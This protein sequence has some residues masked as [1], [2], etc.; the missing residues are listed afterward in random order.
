MNTETAYRITAEDQA[1]LDAAAEIQRKRLV[2]KGAFQA[3]KD[4][5]AYLSAY[6]GHLEHEIFGL[7]H[8]DIAHEIIAIETVFR[9]DIDQASI[10]PR[11]IVKSVLSHN[12][13]A[14]VLFHNHPSGR[15]TPSPEDIAITKRIRDALH[16]IDGRVLDHLIIGGLNG[17][18]MTEH[19]DL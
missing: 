15:C 18:S 19:G 5:I 12:A 13:V 4:A 9:G 10:F 3:P 6:C 7:V 1:I 14:V 11:Q 8:L 2:R 16:L 17:Y